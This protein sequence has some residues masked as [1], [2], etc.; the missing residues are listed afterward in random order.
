MESKDVQQTDAS[1]ADLGCS[2]QTYAAALMTASVRT[3][4]ARMTT[5]VTVVRMTQVMM[6]SRC[7]DDREMHSMDVYEIHS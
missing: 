7:E 4:I 5:M 2:V 1:V 3:S 6:P